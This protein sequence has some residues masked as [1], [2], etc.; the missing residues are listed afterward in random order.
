MNNVIYSLT[1]ILISLTIGHGVFYLVGGI[2]ASL[3]GMLILTFSLHFR[4][5][6]AEKLKVSIQWIIRNMGI[7][8]VPAAVGIIEYVALLKEFGIS[9]TLM[10]MITTLLLMTVVGFLY[11]K[12]ISL[13]H[14][15]ETSK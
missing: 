9:I 2:P 4:V 6:K 10:V 14:S 11:Q 7:C 8:F 13:P 12:F 5:I 1:A 3:Y 15:S